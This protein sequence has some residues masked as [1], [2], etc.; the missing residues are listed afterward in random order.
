MIRTITTVKKHQERGYQM[1]SH[2]TRHLR[3]P[4]VLTVVLAA[5]AFGAAGGTAFALAS[6]S[7]SAPT[8][9]AGTVYACVASGG[10]LAFF[11]TGK[12]P[13]KC[14]SGDV[15]WHWDITGPRGP[16]GGGGAGATATGTTAVTNY[17]DVGNFGDWAVDTFTRT[18]TVTEHGAVAV[19]N[20]GGTPTNGISTCYYYTATMVDTGNFQTDSGAD[21]PDAG[22]AIHGIVSGTLTG[23]SDFEFYATSATPSASHVPATDNAGASTYPSTGDWP[24]VF[25]PAGTSFG[26]IS[27]LNWSFSYTAPNTCEKWVDAYNN[28]HGTGTGAGDITGVNHCTA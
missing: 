16:A 2:I 13:Y 21:S 12:V 18:M 22:V 11:E 25:F 23:G 28:V 20:C 8:Q 5:G 19:S 4:F 26:A 6:A 14:P 9:P 7:S 27:E 17:V 24:E 3:R 15:R 1:F 10:K